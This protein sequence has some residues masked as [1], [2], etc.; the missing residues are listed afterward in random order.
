MA[1]IKYSTPIEPY[2][3]GER[4]ARF[5]YKN[6]THEAVIKIT[7][8]VEGIYTRSTESGNVRYYYDI[9]YDLFIYTTDAVSM[10]AGTD[11]FVFRL[12]QNGSQVDT[13][14]SIYA[15]SGYFNKT[16]NLKDLEA[17]A[18]GNTEEQSVRITIDN[19]YDIDTGEVFEFEEEF[20]ADILPP[21]FFQLLKAPNFSDDI[22]A[23]KI[24]IQKPAGRLLDKN[25]NYTNISLWLWSLEDLRIVISTDGVSEDVS[26]KLVWL[27]EVGVAEYSYKSEFGYDLSNSSITTLKYTIKLTPEEKEKLINGVDNGSKQE[28]TYK[29]ISEPISS[30][31]TTNLET[32]SSD[33]KRTFTLLD[34]SPILNP[35]VEDGNTKT[36]ELTGDI[37]TF[38][39]YHSEAV[40]AINAETKKNATIAHQQITCGNKSNTSPYGSISAVESG[41]FLFSIVDSRD[42][43]AYQVIEKPLIP[44]KHLTANIVKNSATPDGTMIFTISGNYYNGSF[45]AKN[46]SLILRYS[47]RSDDGEDFLD[48]VIVRPSLITINEN[49]TYTATITVNGL[50]YRKDYFVR[51]NIFDALE[52]VTTQETYIG[53]TP[54]FDWG[55]SDFNFNIPVNYSE[56]GVSYSVSDVAKNFS[57]LD[58]SRGD[59]DKVKGLFKAMSNRYELD[60]THLGIGANY[61]N[62]NASLFLYG[63]TIRGYITAKRKS[64][65]SAGNVANEMICQ[66]EFDSGGKVIG[67]GATSFC[68]GSVGGVACYQ[69]DETHIYANDGSVS[70]EQVGR[71]RF[72]LNLCAVASGGDEFNAYFTF[73]ALIDL[74]KY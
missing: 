34:A 39:K 44:Y 66:I 56:N 63:N 43:I 28:I 74:T 38:I 70:P 61:S 22:D 26:R 68:S 37:N 14:K 59:F 1:I 45:G 9:Y 46:N 23:V 53:F 62:V 31:G 65:V 58:F 17:G 8:Y 64:A 12:Y 3:F 4:L 18:D 27:E 5:T 72:D 71:G 49:N 2:E 54:I 32:Y 30:L 6:T 41:T 19:F 40:Y 21:L 69:I 42:L 11:I 50:D 36:A 35:I 55:K 13:S 60:I 48:F 25:D 57:D 73:P 29:L 7:R 10:N 16:L 67:F 33:L 51:V 47:Y 24:E 15:P 52:N 20:T